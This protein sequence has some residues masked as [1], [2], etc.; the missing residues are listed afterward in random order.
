MPGSSSTKYRERRLPDTPAINTLLYFTGRHPKKVKGVRVYQTTYDDGFDNRSER[1]GWSASSWGSS[2]IKTEI[3]LLE[4]RGSYWD[5]SYSDRS[6]NNGRNS[7]ASRPGGGG[8]DPWRGNPQGRR[9]QVDDD[10]SDD[11]DAS[12]HSGFAHPGPGGPPPP[13]MGRPPP[14]MG[15]GFPPGPPP[16]GAFRPGFGPPP[17]MPQGFAGGPPGG[18][19]GGGFPGGGFPPRGTPGP[20]PPPG[21]PPPGH[22]VRDPNGIQVFDTN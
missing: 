9:A 12:V 10:D 22:F 7:R 1:S 16:P 13:M 19:P 3:Y 14:Q 8:R 17:P 11:D 4:T 5:N 2:K 6:S 18:F 15:G 20:G 21:G